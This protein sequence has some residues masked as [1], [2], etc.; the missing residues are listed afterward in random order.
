VAV[1]SFPLVAVLGNLTCIAAGRSFTD[2]S[3]DQ[4][5]HTVAKRIKNP[6]T[7]RL[8]KMALV[9]TWV[10]GSMAGYVSQKQNRTR[11]WWRRDKVSGLVQVF[12]MLKARQHKK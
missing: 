9:S 6:T 7:N 8:A 1:C 10:R 3:Y 2:V 5:C 4:G 12:L 11:V